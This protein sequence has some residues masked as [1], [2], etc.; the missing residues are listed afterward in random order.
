MEKTEN[1]GCQVL[2]KTAV[3]E[4]SLRTVEETGLCT[5]CERY[6]KLGTSALCL[7]PDGGFKGASEIFGYTAVTCKS[8]KKLFSPFDVIEA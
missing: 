6:L 2:S 1:A 5:E 8:Y 4:V 7:G 3:P